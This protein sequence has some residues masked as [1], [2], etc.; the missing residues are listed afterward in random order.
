MINQEH[1]ARHALL[2]ALLDGSPPE[3]AASRAGVAL[4]ARY[5]VL[6]LSLGPQP[7]ETAPGPGAAIAARR[8]LRRLQGVLDHAARA[9]VLSMLDPAGGVVL[10]PLTDPVSAV[11]PVEWERVRAVVDR[12]AHVAGALH[13]AAE[14][15]EPVAVPAAAEQAGEVLAVVQRCGYPPGVYRLRDVLVEYQLS[16]PGDARAQL[17]ALLRPLEEH[18][19]FLRTLQTYV[20]HQRD[21]RRTAAR[22]HIHPNTVDYRLHRVRG[23]TGLDPTRPAD[24]NQ[25]SAALIARNAQQGL[26]S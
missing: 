8:K 10:V 4:P 20:E 22:L 6:R 25:L 15:A 9:A 26:P 2:S 17:A 11:S 23:L 19:Q 16:R 5:V 7:D 12:M 3:P 18:P 1:S 24:L 13:A 14:F 21:R